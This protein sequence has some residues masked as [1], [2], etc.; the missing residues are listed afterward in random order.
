MKYKWYI[1]SLVIVVFPVITYAETSFHRVKPFTI[2]LTAQNAVRVDW[3]GVSSAKRYTVRVLRGDNVITTKT[4]SDTKTKFSADLFKRNRSYTIKVRVQATSTKTASDWRNK[5]F[6]YEPIAQPPSLTEVQSPTALLGGAAWLFFVDDGEDNL[7]VSAE[8]NQSIQMGR[9]DPTNP[10]ADITWQTV[11]TSADTGGQGIADHWHMFAHGYHWI[12]FSTTGASQSYLLQLNTQ[13]ERVA[14]TEVA[15][16]EAGIA[17]NDMFFVAEEDGV[18]V[19]HFNPPDGHT[20]YRFNTA[21]ELVDTTRIGGGDYIHGNGAS[22]YQT[23]SGFIVFA[24][25]DLDP[26]SAS[27]LYKITY[28]ADW[29]EQSIVTLLEADDTD[30]AMGTAVLLDDGSYILHARKITNVSNHTGGDDSGSIVQYRF[31]S[32]DKLVDSTTLVEDSGN[33]PHTLTVGDDVYVT[34]DASGAVYYGSYQMTD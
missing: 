3:S 33:R 1:A 23:D 20:L 4:T 9:F 21:A 19:G 28:S 29:E 15:Q 25:S 31:T 24:P 16:N 34:Y 27:P 32:N 12:V 30:F 11:V 2:E 18:T 22:A 10:D 26:A 13:F 6:T 14:F 5:T 17:T 8:A 7:A